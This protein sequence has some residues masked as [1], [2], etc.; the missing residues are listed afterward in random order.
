MLT[1]KRFLPITLIA[2]GLTFNSLV[3]TANDN[4]RPPNFLLIIADD[5]GVDILNSYG[6]TKNPAN[7]PNLNRLAQSGVSY[8][9]FWVTPACTTTRG[10]LI[11]GQHGFESGVDYVPAV[12]PDKSFTIQSRL[13]QSDITQ[14]YA[15]GVFGK[16][17]L[18]GRNP[19]LNHPAQ[20][21]IDQYAGNLFNL[22]NY[23]KW[24]MTNNGK[25]TNEST[26]HTTKVTDLA[27]QFIQRNQGQP[28]FTWLAYSAP[29]SPFHNPPANLVSSTN[30]ASQY[31]QMVEAMD[32]EIGRLLNNIPA[33]DRDNTVI[34]FLG[35]NGTPRR[36]RDQ[37]LF[38]SNHV[39][40]STYEGG[41]RTPLII[42]GGPVKRQGVREKAMVN[43][44]DFFATLVD[45]AGGKGQ[46]PNNS[47]SFRG[48]LDGSNNTRRT[49]N[50]SEWKT[51]RGTD[52]WTVRD[53]THKAIQYS[54]GKKELYLTS[55]VSERSP[56]NDVNK[57]N[58]LINKG[59][60]LRA[61]QPVTQSQA[62]SRP[63]ANTQPVQLAPSTSANFKISVQG[64][65]RCFTGNG[66]PNHD[67]G[68]FPNSGNPNRISEQSI[69]LCVD[70]NPVKNAQANTNHRGSVGIAL[71]GV[72]FR[73]ATADYYDAN[74]P[75]GFS[76]DRSSGWN[77]EGIGARDQLGIDHQ[78]AHVDNRGLYHYHSVSNPL[79]TKTST[80]IGYAADGFE[81]HYAGNN[82]RS[83]YQ[84]K[85]GNRATAPNGP[86][87]GKF[88]EDWVYQAGSG[89]LDQCNG[90]MANGKFVYFATT[91]YP[92]FPRCFW[93]N[94]SQD[95]S[96]RGGNQQNQQTGQ[97]RQRRDGQ[98]QQN[99]P[100][101][102]QRGNQAQGNRQGNRG[103]GNR[104]PRVVACQGKSAG[105]ACE[106]TTPRGHERSGECAQN[107]NN[108]LACRAGRR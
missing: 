87:D 74:S 79:I 99:R 60:Q 11:T 96:T 52:S 10:A 76:R 90:G 80:L 16:W 82:Q 40:G 66:L 5:L 77:L 107:G 75:R 65:K 83:S 105:A 24:V 4:Q 43:A 15:T 7:T 53:A 12:M 89:S 81:I 101:R 47:F 106:F 94:P 22:D 69:N 1:K 59:N 29:H 6:L 41:I 97:N 2:L 63:A 57:L 54:D 49:F 51:N 33:A 85:Q 19:D 37:Q 104:P 91:T 39:K 46:I 9:N 25:Q 18:G 20:F 42:A 88:V 67:T 27:L 71:N 32:T 17:H 30:G 64:N 68:T 62:N 3:A 86:H 55:D 61:K 45:F 56:V 73:P 36:M 26:Y 100:N 58:A 103:Q 13:K 84:L 92:F 8:D 34:I 78:N 50:Y 21:G 28:W 23:D 70:A 93:G 14:A 102:Q 108:G 35:D 31:Q 44:T 72:Q 48:T 38:D 98:A 95:F